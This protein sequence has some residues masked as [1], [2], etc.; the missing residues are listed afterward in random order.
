MPKDGKNRRSGRDG[1]RGNDLAAGLGSDEDYDWIKYL[2]EGRSSA[3]A[4]SEQPPAPSPAQTVK[5]PAARPAPLPQRVRPANAPQRGG[6][7][8]GRQEQHTGYE[9]R[10]PRSRD[11]RPASR[12][13]TGRAVKVRPGRTTDLL[14]NPHA[15][16]Y[17]QP[18]YPAVDD[19]QRRATPSEQDWQ[20]DWQDEDRPAP[21]RG[22]RLPQRRL[23]TA[24][25]A[26]PLYPGVGAGPATG[27]RPPRSWPQDDPLADTDAGGQRFPDARRA[28]SPGPSAPA[29]RP[30]PSAPAVRPSPSAPAVRP[31]PSPMLPGRVD[32]TG[33]Q[34]RVSELSPADPAEGTGPGRAAATTSR[35][36]RATAQFTAATSSQR[37]IADPPGGPATD[38]GAPQV[39]PQVRPKPVRKPRKT[40]GPRAGKARPRG[41]KDRPTAGQTRSGASRRVPLKV[42]IMLGS[43]IVAALAVAGYV[44]FRPQASHV[45]SAPASLG[46]YVRQ[47]ANATANDL[48]HRIVAAAGG[49]VKNVVAAVYQRTT[50]PGT[51]K[52]PQIVVF[53]GGNLAG[54][55]SADSLISAY[56]TR[57]R[58]ALTTGAGRLGGQAACAPGSNGG[59]AECAWADNDTFGVVVSATLNSA[60]LADVM[61]E[62]RPQ[63][64]HVGR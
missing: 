17:S 43:A 31:G 21:Q 57:L 45:V 28:A 34:R 18:L 48:R 49:A 8:A 19:S 51:K 13:V 4:A 10:Q 63:V 1:A 62:I 38:A 26:R 11:A 2:G 5:R 32:R 53:I 42:V 37:T 55:A 41:G 9:A 39:Q 59:P 12:P 7:P 64:E 33:P 29:V 27:A 22:D 25:Y 61:R 52:G 14:F 47:Q 60:G 40:G 58:G 6:E 16:D 15:D 35:S 23:D 3:S 36:A 30:S 56:M 46:A 24:E 50:G 20:R 54:G 44:V